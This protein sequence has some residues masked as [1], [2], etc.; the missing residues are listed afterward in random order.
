VFSSQKAV[1]EWVSAVSGSAAFSR[2]W[3]V[4]SE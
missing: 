3:V 4:S 2:C 1:E